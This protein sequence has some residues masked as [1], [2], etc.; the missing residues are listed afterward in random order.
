MIGLH[1]TY[2]TMQMMQ[3]D[4]AHGASYKHAVL[5]GVHIELYITW[6][7][8]CTVLIRKFMDCILTNLVYLVRLCSS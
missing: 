3:C 7:R 6:M 4:V 1:G 5:I 2:I 8:A